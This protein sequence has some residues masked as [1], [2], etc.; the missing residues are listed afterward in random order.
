MYNNVILLWFIVYFLIITLPSPPLTDSSCIV[1][2]TCIFD[3]RDTYTY[4]SL[5]I[6]LNNIVQIQIKF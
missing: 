6:V 4:L 5:M 1:I 2:S 3:I